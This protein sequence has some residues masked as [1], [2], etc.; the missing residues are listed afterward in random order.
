MN[1]RWVGTLLFVLLFVVALIILAEVFPYNNRMDNPLNR[2]LPLRGF[3]LGQEP[4]VWVGNSPTHQGIIGRGRENRPI[5][6]DVD[7]IKVS[8]KWYKVKGPVYITKTGRIIGWH[9]DI[10]HHES[11][12]LG[13][14][15]F[16]F[17][18][19]EEET[20]QGLR[21]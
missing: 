8:G 9:Q 4:E 3:I 7:F 11:E 5:S 6:I 2:I 19:Q 13:K 1:H 10:T 14:W 17:L 12:H 15:Q 16:R 21:P 18:S 20:L